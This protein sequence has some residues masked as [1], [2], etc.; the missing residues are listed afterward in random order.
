MGQIKSAAMDGDNVLQCTE[1][2]LLMD[3]KIIFEK[4]RKVEG[5]DA[6]DALEEVYA[7]ADGWLKRLDWLMRNRA[8]PT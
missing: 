6:Y 3:A 5:P 8:Q 1:N 4:V 2:S 7:F